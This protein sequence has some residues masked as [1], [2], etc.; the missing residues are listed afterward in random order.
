[1][2]KK[3][4]RIIGVIICLLMILG[5]FSACDRSGSA[6]TTQT[7]TATTRTTTTAG[8]AE[9]KL[10]FVEDG[11]VTLSV[12]IVDN[13]YAPASYAGNLPIFVQIQ[14]RTGIKIEWEVAG[15][16][17]YSTMMKTRL[18][19]GGDDLPDILHL[20]DDVQDGA[21]KYGM[22]G[23][24][25]PLEG[26][27]EKFGPNL[28]RLYEEQPLLKA[29]TYAPDGHSYVVAQ[30]VQGGNYVNYLNFVIR[31]DWLDKLS[32]SEPVTI[33]DWANVLRAFKEKDPNGSNTADEVPFTGV[34]YQ[35]LFFTQAWGINSVN[36]GGYSF[37]WDIKDDKV[38]YGFTSPEFKE[39]LTWLNKMYDEGLIDN[40]F[41]T[42]DGDKVRAKINRNIAG[43]S[44]TF[45][46]NIPS[47]NGSLQASDVDDANFIAVAPPKGPSGIQQIEVRS[48]LSWT[49]GISS[50]SK[51]PEYAIKLLDYLAASPEGTDYGMFGILGE[52][53]VIENGA[54]KYTDNVLR[55]PEGK[56]AFDVLRA[57]GAYHNLPYTQTAESVAAVLFDVYPELK[58]ISESN[59]KYL[60]DAFPS[61][62]PTEDESEAIARISTDLNTY[63]DEMIMKFIIGTENLDKYDEYVKNLKSMGLDELISIKQAQL[64][65]FSKNLK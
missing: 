47:F 58:I 1:M 43:A 33:D 41:P 42:N 46:S 61:I 49:F 32:L 48:P 31:K 65:R 60:V 21:V 7:T 19:V 51:Y 30:N 36:V 22:A 5:A 40:E 13:W 52:T 44:L 27:I 55:N 29:L 6:Q 45:L 63:K 11:S 15:Y 10:P 35:I 54:R 64:D 17:Q 25:Q 62:L 9:M 12:A 34:D 18:A 56:G 37:G 59:R 14:E 8:S 26:L 53:Y 57:V 16:E 23:V 20:P 38:V 2:M 39:A 28:T 3:T 50:K 4:N 24:I